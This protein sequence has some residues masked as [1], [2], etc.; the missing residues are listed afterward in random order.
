MGKYRI[1]FISGDGIGPEVMEEAL[2]VLRAVEG[3]VSGLEMEFVKCE[4]G[5]KVYRGTGEAL[6]R[7]TITDCEESHAI[8]KGPVGLPQVVKPD[9]MEAATDVIL[10]LRSRFN[11]YVNLRPIELYPG[12]PSPLAGKGGGDI[13]YVIARENTEGLYVLQGGI[14]HD[15]V[16]TN[17]RITTRKGTE[18]IVRYAFNYARR[19]GSS[20][21]DGVKRVTCVDSS[22]VL[23]SDV[24]FRRI[25]DE[26]AGDYPDVE[27]DYAYVDAFTIGQIMRPE[28]YH[29]VVTP[30]LYGDIV[31]DLAGAT[32]GSVGLVAGGNIGDEYAM[33]EPIHGS[34]P[35][36]AGRGLA[37]PLAMVQA[38]KM[39]MRWLGEK[40]GDV[41]ATAAAQRIEEAV[42]TVLGRGRELTFDLGGKAGTSDVGDELAQEIQGAPHT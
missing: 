24:F 17:L 4:A 13:N 19:W 38:G 16:A 2:K 33:F 9:G 7:K 22:K 15:M 8:F 20:P 3:T 41:S 34:A 25:F 10:G 14:L 12:V 1:A 30:N 29:V 23:V 6:P 39:M 28:Y 35:T 36:L 11:L 42:K 32:V 27:R 31:S 37:N 40:Y 18:R 21:L 26:I 5:A